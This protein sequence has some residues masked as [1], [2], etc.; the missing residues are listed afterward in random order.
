MKYDFTSIIDRHGKDSSAIESVGV[1]THWM[2]PI[3][4]KEGFDF[5][6]MWVADMNFATCPSIPKAIIERAKHPL[7]GYF[8]PRKE[9]FDAIIKWHE[10]QYG[11]KGLLREHIGYENGVHGGNLT[12]LK[13]LCSPGSSVLL[14]VPVYASFINNLRSCGYNGVFSQLKKDEK[15]IY[16]MDFADMEQKIK[17]NRIHAMVFCSP[18]NPLG[19]VWEWWELE[20]LMELCRKYD[21][22][23]VSDEIW[24]DLTFE[25]HP[26]I[27]T[28]SISE[29]AR[30]RTI[31]MYAPSKTFNLAGLIGSYH[32]IYNRRLRDLV[33]HESSLTH[34]NNMNVLSMHA[35]IAAYGDEGYEWVDELR[36]VLSC[37][38][39]YAY[40]Y[41]R[42][43]FC[44]VE[45][46]KPEGTYMFFL[47]C[48]KWCQEHGKDVSDI[49]HAGWDVG[50]GWQDGRQFM[51]PNHIRMNLAVP[52][53]RVK[54]AFDR[55]D[56]YVFNI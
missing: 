3:A 39:K 40:E 17:D 46:P 28:Q 53:K 45:A 6:P 26:H 41:V 56:K 16:R 51:G 42:D 19:R 10:K 8:N 1:S 21:V 37:N 24:A 20:E 4:P 14:N 34:Y 43:H 5:I 29:D 23:V 44:G 36:Q 47:D 55:L 52:F 7:Y 54:E 33:D 31:A 30:M 35:L 9:Y 38:T 25:G 18:Q 49:L 11:T 48:T 2:V 50:V 27:P 32:V 22:Y 13:V 15:G 12:A